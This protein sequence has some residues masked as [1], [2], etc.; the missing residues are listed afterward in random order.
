MIYGGPSTRQPHP[1]PD[2]DV[3]L[4]R[5]AK[6]L[7]LHARMIARQKAH[8]CLH[9]THLILS[10]LEPP[11]DHLM[12]L[13][14]M[15]G[16]LPS[17]HDG[18]RQLLGAK[19][20]R[21]LEESLQ[22]VPKLPPREKEEEG[23]GRDPLIDRSWEQVI[24]KAHDIRLESEDIFT[25]LEHLVHALVVCEA[26]TL[27]KLLDICK[28]EEK[29]IL[30]LSGAPQKRYLED[31]R[32]TSGEE[33]LPKVAPMWSPQGGDY[34]LGV[35][36]AQCKYDWYPFSVPLHLLPGSCPLI[37]AVCTDLTRKAEAGQLS[38]RPERED[39]L[40]KLA[41]QMTHSGDQ[42]CVLLGKT[43]VGKTAI[44][45][46]FA[47]CIAFGRVPGLPPHSTRLLS[48]F[49]INIIAGTHRA[50]ALKKRIGALVTEI[51]NCKR[52]GLNVII[53]MGKYLPE[54]GVVDSERSPC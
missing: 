11:P 54:G 25:D 46:E 41:V 14:S 52:A 23:Q 9:A 18:N 37:S 15:E 2:P 3:M 27:P 33:E 50:G 35:R 16:Y 42:S 30:Q 20:K 4:S 17:L 45:E 26:S 48:L 43:G 1:A 29:F 28:I 12:Y 8:G 47:R 40:N 6:D 5:R 24:R 34:T 7:I 22:G 19:C 31:R 38:E 10:L 36:L 13:S 39:I 53:F 32:R 49:A 21:L 44:V 51:H